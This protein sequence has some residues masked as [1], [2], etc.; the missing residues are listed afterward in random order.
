MLGAQTRVRTWTPTEG[1]FIGFA[2]THNESISIANYLTYKNTQ[3]NEIEYR[4]TVHYA[5]H[6]CDDAVLSLHELEGNNWNEHLQKHKLAIFH[7]SILLCS[8]GF[9]HSNF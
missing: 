5:Y 7:F 3:T 9:F 1:H 6:P 2:I 8:I 4:P